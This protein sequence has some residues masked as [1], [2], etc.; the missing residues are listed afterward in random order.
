MVNLPLPALMLLAAAT[1][2]ATATARD[3]ALY[4]IALDN[5]SGGTTMRRAVSGDFDGDF[6]RDVVVLVDGLPNVLWAPSIYGW[7]EELDEIGTVDDVDA[8]PSAGGT[9]DTLVTV[10]SAGLVEWSWSPASGAF[11]GTTLDSSLVW[12]GADAV[13]AADLDGTAPIDFVGIAHSGP[14]LA[15]LTR[16]GSTTAASTISLS[17]SDPPLR[18]LAPVRWLSNGLDQVAV[19]TDGELM[20]VEVGNGV[21]KTYTDGGTTPALAAVALDGTAQEGI[22]WART[23]GTNTNG[24]A[25]RK[26]ASLGS[27]EPDRNLGVYTARGLASG[28]FDGDGDG[29]LYAAGS[30]NNYGF[31]MNQV[32]PSPAGSA[33]SWCITTGCSY[34][35]AVSATHVAGAAPGVLVTDIDGDGDLDA[36]CSVD[37]AVQATIQNGLLTS[38]TAHRLSVND[39]GEEFNYHEA[40]PT[41]AFNVYNFP[42]TFGTHVEVTIRRELDP[43]AAEVTFSTT[44]EPIE[45]FTLSGHDRNDPLNVTV[46]LGAP[47]S[48]P[49][50]ENEYVAIQ[51]RVVDIDPISD[52]VLDADHEFAFVLTIHDGVGIKE[53]AGELPPV[54]PVR[55]PMPPPG[56]GG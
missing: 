36:L 2:A 24:L 17:P 8:V 52:D 26:H 37:G 22:A 10:S 49:P 4:S 48:A 16:G 3:G 35:I 44:A 14:A 21:L 15:V 1:G 29:D 30:F 31:F 32:P 51:I 56:G 38:E 50:E 12:A 54:N 41:V 33:S 53:G 43:T 11:V 39:E 27:Q 9:V 25:L 42:T 45:R 40:G 19:A 28:D 6:R 47:F 55:P 18:T 20:I 34:A 5:P 13:R 46:G 7:S 23:T